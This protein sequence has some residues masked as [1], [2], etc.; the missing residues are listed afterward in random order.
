MTKQTVNR[1]FSR[2]ML[3][4]TFVVATYFAL[5]HPPVQSITSANALNEVTDTALVGIWE[6]TVQG[7][8]TYHYKYAISVGTWVT[9]GD[10]DQGFLGYRFSPTTGAYVKNADESYSYRERGWTYNRGGVCNGSFES[11][12]T[13][14]LDASGNTF[15]GPGVFKM[16]DLAGNTIITENLTVLATRIPV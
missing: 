11:T 9:N 15:S 1:L 13:F 3:L 8:A 4:A 6:M 10:V 2:T 16:F 12:G 14:V 7:N 5:S